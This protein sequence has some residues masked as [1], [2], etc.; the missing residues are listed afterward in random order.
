MCYPCRRSKL[1]PMFQV[2]HDA[3]ARARR[4]GEGL[5][6]RPARFVE[7]PPPQPSPAKCGRGSALPARVEL[8]LISLFA[9]ASQRQAACRKTPRFDLRTGRSP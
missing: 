5:F 3:L 1:L 2:A 4:V 6:R 9:S 7:T 8:D